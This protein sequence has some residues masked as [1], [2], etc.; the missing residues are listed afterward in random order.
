MAG[1]LFVCIGCLCMLCVLAVC[2][3]LCVFAAAMLWP[4]GQ[5]AILCLR[6]MVEEWPLQ[7]YIPN[8]HSSVRGSCNTCMASHDS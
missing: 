2:C 7:C 4:G 3:G 8:D 1:W 6:R 5:L